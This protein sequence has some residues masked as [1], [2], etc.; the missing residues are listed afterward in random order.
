MQEQPQEQSFW[1]S[2]VG[3]ICAG[4]LIVG[5]FFL[6][7]EHTAP[8]FAAVVA[9]AGLPADAPVHAPRPWSIW[10]V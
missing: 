5:G 2:P 10:R 1:R 7:T 6:L 8:F 4:F 3:I 9:D